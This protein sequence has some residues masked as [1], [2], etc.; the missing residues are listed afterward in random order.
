[1]KAVQY[2]EFG[3]PLNVAHI[4]DVGR[5]IPAA[6]DVLIKVEATPFRYADIYLIR[7]DHGFR[8]S[9]PAVPG[10]TGIGRVAEIGADV[11]KFKVGDR[12]YLPRAGTWREFMTW[13]AAELFKG[14]RDGEPVDLAQVNSNGFTAHTLLHHGGDLKRGDWVIQSAANSNCGRYIIQLAKPMGIRTVNIVRRP[15]V[16]DD[17]KALGADVVVVDG[18]DLPS[19]VSEATGGADIHLGFDMVGGDTTGHMAACL[20]DRGQIALYGQ[21][22]PAEARVPIN[23]MLFK[24]LTLFGLLGESQFLRSGKTRDEFTLVYEEVSDLILKGELRSHIAKVYSLG[25]IHRAIEHFIDG[26]D[27]KIIIVPD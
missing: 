25:Q 23:L 20:A 17:L 13:P 6:G 24:H 15:D 11:T 1:M 16:A 18:E 27:G 4:V 14:P 19:R 8:P 5:P 9:L 3:D 7:G 22:G 21:V 10:G 26:T 12:V 2:T